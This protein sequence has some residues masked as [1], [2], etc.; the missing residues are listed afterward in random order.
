MKVS[1]VSTGSQKEQKLCMGCFR[2]Q[3]LYT[4]SLQTATWIKVLLGP[5]CSEA[6]IAHASTMPPKKKDEKPA[7]EP[8]DNAEDNQ[9]AMETELLITILRSKLGRYGTRSS[10]P[11][12]SSASVLGNLFAMIKV[13]IS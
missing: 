12:R 8:Q 10:A 11:T 2:L 7:P 9:I 3:V 4:L 5:F 13:C 6:E 1:S